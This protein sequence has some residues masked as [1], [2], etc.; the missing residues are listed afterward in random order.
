MAGLCIFQGV[1]SQK[2]VARRWGWFQG[3]K[4]TSWTEMS[5]LSVATFQKMM[6]SRDIHLTWLCKSGFPLYVC[7]HTKLLHSCPAL[8]DPIV[9]CQVPLSME[10]PTGVGGYF[11][12]QGI[13]LTQEWNPRLLCLLHCRQILYCWFTREAHHY[14]YI[15]FLNDV[16]ALFKKVFHIKS[17]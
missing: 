15:F 7:V 9:A 14:A 10:F 12:L 3:E 13:L 16:F 8:C 5:R 17:G 1:L 4:A 11:L 6:G 2:I